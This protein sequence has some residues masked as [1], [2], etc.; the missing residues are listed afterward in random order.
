KD[1]HRPRCGS[2]RRE[3]C[4]ISREGRTARWQPAVPHRFPWATVLMAEV[5][6]RR[7]KSKIARGIRAFVEN[8][9]LYVCLNLLVLVLGLCL[10]WV[11]RDG[12]REFLARFTA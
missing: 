12:L 2:T 11:T 1:A 6:K 3:K 8:L 9:K 4:S 10:I 7:G 5:E